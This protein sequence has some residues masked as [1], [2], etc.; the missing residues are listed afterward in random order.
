MTSNETKM[1]TTD[2]TEKP[3]YDELVEQLER[4]ANGLQWFVESHPD[5]M[6]DA[7]HEVLKET[8]DLVARARH[9]TTIKMMGEKDA[10]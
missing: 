9:D 8:N 2:S 5:L 10:E 4:M 7:D 3:T 1:Q 6:N